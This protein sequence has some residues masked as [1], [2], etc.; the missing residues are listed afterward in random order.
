MLRSTSI[1]ASCQND[2]NTEAQ[3]SRGTFTLSWYLNT[4]LAFKPFQNVLTSLPLWT[5]HLTR[6]WKIMWITS[7]RSILFVEIIIFDPCH[8]TH[9]VNELLELRL[10]QIAVAIDVGLIDRALHRRLWHRDVAV[11]LNW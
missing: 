9:L 2:V 10:V 11:L 1:M 4:S 7:L 8:G 6:V 5:S 3:H